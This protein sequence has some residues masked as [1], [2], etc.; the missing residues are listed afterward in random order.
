M[1]S[2][3]NPYML[4]IKIGGAIL[5]GAAIFGA[6]MWLEGTIKDKTI[7]AMQR[8]QEKA[9]TVNVT[10]SLNQLQIFISKMNTASAGYESD[11]A[12]LTAKLNRISKD[13]SDAIKAKPLPV[14]CRPDD[15][16]LHNLSAAV[17]ATND[18][19]AGSVAS[20]TVRSH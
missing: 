6:G 1:F 10:A 7:L 18:T 20:G 15:M 12:T 19:A 13:F 16:R 3:L 4:L 8:E 5:A 14:D 11:K 2:F 9:N 17:K